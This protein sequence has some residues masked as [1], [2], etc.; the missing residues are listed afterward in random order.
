MADSGG[1]DHVALRAAVAA[2]PGELSPELVET[3]LALVRPALEL[4]V[5]DDD[6]SEADDDDLEDDDLEDQDDIDEDDDEDDED[7]G[8]DGDGRYVGTYGGLPP[9][10]PGVDWPAVDG[11][12]LAVL[13]QLHCAVLADLLGEEWTLP[14]DGVLVF[15]NAVWRGEPEACRVLH[16]P[17][18]APVR[19]APEGAEVIPPQPLGAWWCGSAPDWEDPALNA[20]FRE[21]GPDLIDVLG[22]L[23]PELSYTPHQVL[24]W[25]GS[26]YH[27]R[28]EGF[29]PLLQLEGEQ[30]TAWGELVR[31][32]FVVPEEDL[33]DG[34]LDRVR[35]TYEVA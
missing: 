1:V 35:M 15:F 21:H 30:G 7:E 23:E 17:G 26:G 6:E 24:G 32:A 11:E 29:R 4:A 14:G 10:P 22:A 27:P 5:V 20:V 9:L 3:V 12:P 31:L 13:A 16:V 18:D 19:D 2:H 25:L 33:R 8:D 28:R 34:R